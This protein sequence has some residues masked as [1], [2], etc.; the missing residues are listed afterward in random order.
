M[1]GH[2]SLYHPPGRNIHAN[3]TV[4]VCICFIQVQASTVSCY[5]YKPTLMGMENKEA[6]HI[7]TYEHEH[8]GRT[9]KDDRAL[10]GTAAIR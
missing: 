8:K 7:K 1:N 2:T 9:D 5:L 6:H 4:L 3:E 10:P